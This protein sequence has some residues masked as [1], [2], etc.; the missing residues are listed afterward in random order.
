[1]S[2]RSGGR[3]FGK[4]HESLKLPVI[5]TVGTVMHEPPRPVCRV[6][7]PAEPIQW[8]KRSRIN[9]SPQNIP[10]AS[11]S[12]PPTK[13]STGRDFE[14]TISQYPGSNDAA[15]GVINNLDLFEARLHGEPNLCRL[16]TSQH[17]SSPSSR[18]SVMP[19]HLFPFMDDSSSP[20]LLRGTM[21]TLLP[22]LSSDLF[23]KNNTIAARLREMERGEVLQKLRAEGRRLGMREVTVDEFSHLVGCLFGEE[24]LDKDEV[25]YLF[26]FLYWNTQD[27]ISFEDLIASVSLIFEEV[28]VLILVRCKYIME[29][30]TLNNSV[31]SLVDVD[32]MLGAFKSVFGEYVP[33]VCE[34]CADVRRA[35]EDIMPT[36]T[37]PA[38]TFR[39]EI[40]R[41]ELLM[42]CL[43]VV[44]TD[45]S[46]GW[47]PLLQLLDRLPDDDCK[48]FGTTHVELQRALVDTAIAKWREEPD[49]SVSDDG[50][51]CVMDL[52]HPKFIADKYMISTN[53]P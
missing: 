20:R 32:I 18:A 15:S 41:H 37:V 29:E 1:M 47:L 52:C 31:I 9:K 19:E 36:Y 40:K 42:N 51:D 39:E 30:R 4:S 14:I 27:C 38:S 16:L 43:D 2:S 25:E 26:R 21:I 8:R 12:V 45:G 46:I 44:H 34:L 17:E 11:V 10:D 28:D 48:S 53:V 23:L 5:R 49:E 24:L 6:I 13:D 50:K 22:C 3:P 33:E 35:M 7:S